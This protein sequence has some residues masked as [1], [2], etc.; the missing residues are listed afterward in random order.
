VKDQYGAPAGEY[1]SSGTGSGTDQTKVCPGGSIEDC[2]KVCP[3][4]TTRVFGACMRG[5]ADR[6]P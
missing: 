1:D 5:C 2:V 4:T 6:C 3:G